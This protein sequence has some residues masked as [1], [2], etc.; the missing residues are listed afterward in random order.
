[1]LLITI[2][3][4]LYI[5]YDRPWKQF[6]EEF[7]EL[8]YSVKSREYQ[9]L[10]LK[11]QNPG[12]SSGE[13][14]EKAL[15]SLKNQLA[16]IPDR[17]AKIN[18]LWLQE[19]GEVDRCITCHQGI[20]KSGFERAP[21]PFRTHSGDYLKHHPVN[22]FGCVVCHDGQ[23]PGLTV[24]DAHGEVDN[25]IRPILRGHYA[26]SSCG[27]CHFM[28]QTLPL[29][30]E[31]PGASQFSEGWRLF[32]KYNCT[33]C[34]KLSGYER[35][36][37]IAPELTQIGNKVYREWLKKWLKNPGGYL[38]NARMPRFKLSDKEIDSIIAYF[39][40]LTPSFSVKEESTQVGDPAKGERL[41]NT[42]GCLGCHRINNKGNDFAPD[43]SKIGNK[44]KPEWLLWWLK[45][46]QSQAH[47]PEI[48]I[49]EKEIRD[50][51]AYLINLKEEISSRED[52]VSV[53][54]EGIAEGRRLVKD[55]GC[56]GCHKIG[57]LSFQYNAPELDGIGDKRPDR[58]VFGN[59]SSVEKTLINWLKIKIIAPDRFATDR[60]ITR[61]PDYG[62]NDQQA[63]AL[64][65]FLLS[66]RNR[67]VPEGYKKMLIDFNGPEVRGKK[68]FEKYNC[69]GCHK[70]NETG[71]EIGPALTI[72]ARKS[73]P[74]W[75]FNFLK[76]PYKI[77][78]VQ[79]LKA[80]MP[81]FKLSDKE[82][83]TIIEYLTFIA[84]EPYPYNLE[85]KKEVYPEDIWNGE[86]LYHEIFACSGCHSINGRGGEI[87]PD[88]TDL[89]SRL[90]REWTEQ[91][92]QNP[93]AI[94]PD[95]RMP[96]FKFKD[97]QFEA[98]T[99]YLMTLG[100]YRF[101]KIKRSE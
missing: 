91:W 26:Q 5:E 66:L 61:M 76:R 37:R 82:I 65:I 92:L 38:P 42:L 86:K 56:T 83:N 29:T 63:E 96:R 69:L 79:I 81:D 57:N 64:V 85:E 47:I 50:I 33:G 23:G 11:K 27:R 58:L 10:L 94:K 15:N 16:L 90:K 51:T 53:S 71:G 21:Q 9:R 7:K 68:V 60:I 2:I 36:G 22:K 72:E 77:R 20:D 32:Q 41:V 8:E 30:S 98:L 19:L 99:D 6:Q 74:E 17:K 14:V 84:G 25:W 93:Q 40:S 100:D 95:V 45:P 73:R 62:F 78:P 46:G 34:H 70:I 55:F 80:S 13:D 39:L 1:L 59:I 49:S 89:A 12:D 101:L 3:L 75:L 87:G 31:L 67:P 43:L 48:R 54:D 4:V 52:N 35:P 88:H 28:Q 24:K 44:V 97:W 18:Q